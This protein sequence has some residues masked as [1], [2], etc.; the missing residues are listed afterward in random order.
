MYIQVLWRP[1]DSVKSLN[2]NY[3]RLWIA[4]YRCWEPSLGPLPK[5]YVVLTA[6]PSLQ[7][8]NFSMKGSL[9]PSETSFSYIRT[10]SLQWFDSFLQLLPE[11]FW[12]QPLHISW[13]YK[14]NAG[15]G[16]RVSLNL[17]AW[18]SLKRS[19]SQVYLLRNSLDLGQDLFLIMAL[20]PS[21]LNNLYHYSTKSS[22]KYL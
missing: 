3:R 19:F 13:H 11:A 21:C 4:W 9:W 5:Q 22:L 15:G 7:H 17:T 14:D 12:Q 8:P 16:R 6:E 20:L 1:E 10:I 18:N 2:W